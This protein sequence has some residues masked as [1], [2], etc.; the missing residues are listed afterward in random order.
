MHPRGETGINQFKC[1]L[2]THDPA[3]EIGQDE[4]AFTVVGPF[5]GGPHLGGVGAQSAPGQSRGKLNT[6]IQIRDEPGGESERRLRELQR[7]RD[8]DEAGHEAHPS[9]TS[10]RART[11]RA[12]EEAPGSMCPMERSPR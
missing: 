1:R 6:N 7:V 9:T 10:A 5:N 12:A 8:E 4:N 2:G 11:T 3:A